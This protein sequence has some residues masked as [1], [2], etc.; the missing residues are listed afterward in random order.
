M[1]DGR[2]QP[3][4]RK[5]LQITTL[6]PYSEAADAVVKQWLNDSMGQ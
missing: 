3:F 2:V 5:D 4:F 1:R 6:P